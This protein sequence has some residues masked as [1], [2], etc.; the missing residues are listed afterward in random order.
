MI[1]DRDLQIIM[2]YIRKEKKNNTPNS[3]IIKELVDKGIDELQATYLVEH[4]DQN[5]WSSKGQILDTKSQKNTAIA[6]IVLT[7]C[8]SVLYEYNSLLLPSL[9]P[10]DRGTG[11]VFVII[12][13]VVILL[14]YLFYRSLKN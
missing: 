11:L 13:A 5:K 12:L 14:V 10:N 9:Q 6:V 8:G 1:S 7:T 4:S 3:L 2:N